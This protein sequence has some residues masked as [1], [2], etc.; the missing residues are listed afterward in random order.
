MQCLIKIL[1]MLLLAGCALHQDLMKPSAKLHVLLDSGHSPS[2]TGALA[3][4]GATEQS[5]NRALTVRIAEEIG[6]IPGVSQ[7]FTRNFDRD[8]DLTE[9]VVGSSKA[10]L[11]LS[12]HHDS[13]QARDRTISR[14]DGTA[15]FCTNRASGFSLHISRKNPH[16]DQSLIFAR[17]LGRCLLAAGLKANL[18][19]GLTID[20]ESRPVLEQQHAI[21]A[22]DD[23]VVLKHSQ[24]PALLLEAGV[25]ANPLDEEF[26]SRD[27]TRAMIARAVASAVK[28]YKFDEERK[29][30]NIHNS[31]HKF[32]GR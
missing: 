8:V 2:N 12:I 19:H 31:N 17:L 18:Y 9:R 11:L 20:G 14:L 15:H 16:F 4:S 6:T 21:F 32:E 7:S 22:G 13:V 30:I 1:F 25:I 29:L 23:L 24:A 28:Q 27:S 10:D 3:C 26:L 5:F